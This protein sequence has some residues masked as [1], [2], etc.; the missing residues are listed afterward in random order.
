[1]KI[2]VLTPKKE[3]NQKQINRLQALG[4]VIF[5]TSRKEIPLD[6]LKKLTKDSNIIAF[7]PDNI[8][9]FEVASERLL[10]LM[11]ATP[12]L[13]GLALAT[14]DFSFVDLDY[15]KKNNV[16]VTNVPHYS[17]ESVAEHVLAFLLGASKRI[18]ITDRATQKGEFKLIKGFELKGKTLGV[19]GL[20]SI[21]SRVA[22]LGNA[23]GMKVIAYN[24]TAK[25]QQ[26]VEIISLDKL[27][28]E[29]DAISLN[30]ATNKETIKLLSEK[31]IKIIKHGAIVINTADR[32]LV[33]EKAMARSLN[34]KA[35][36]SYVFE[37][38]NLEAS[39]LKN[40]DNAIFF[41]GFGWYTEDALERN[42]E[43]WISNI[44][45]IVNGKANC[46]VS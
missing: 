20:G 37:A 45:G 8:G 18:F 24:R 3:F 35:I 44:E 40:L 17:S 36:D 26:N 6:K 41:R 34:T 33:D 31:R 12:S 4:E 22:E 30:L 5:T 7:D 46:K 13:Q 28:K 39:P 43:I 19:I 14:T 11:K 2:V 27:L 1:M 10:K 29:S 21:G 25:K 9:G 16:V 15:C 32:K 42:K 23:V 38:E